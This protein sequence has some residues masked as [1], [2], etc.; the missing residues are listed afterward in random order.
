MAVVR[1]RSAPPYALI[2]FVGLWLVSTAIAVL[3]YVQ[4][5]KAEKELN[6]TTAR[7][8]RVGNRA[9]LTTYAPTLAPDKTST[10]LGTAK[11]RLDTLTALVAGSPTTPFNDAVARA[12]SAV[13]AA[14]HADN[15]SL[16]AVVQA[17]AGDRDTK[18]KQ[19]A[20]LTGQMNNVNTQ[21]RQGSEQFG[22]RVAA[23]QSDLDDT[24]RKLEAAL[25]DAQKNAASRDEAVSKAQQQ[26]S[27]A[28]A[29]MEEER[30]GSTLEMQQLRNQIARDEQRIQELLVVIRNRTSGGDQNTVGEAD[31]QIVSVNPADNEC[32]IN[33]ARNIAGNRVQAGLTFTVFDPRSGVRFATEA[34]A[35]GKGTIEIIQVGETSSLCR[36]THTTKGQAIQAG[37]LVANLVF[38]ANR[39]RTFRFVVSGDFDLD[40]DGVA[41]A[42]ERE[43]LT[44]LITSWGGAIDNDVSTQ[45][46][47]VVMGQRPAAP[48][49]PV[50][51]ATAPGGAGNQ[52][53]QQQKQYDE[54]VVEAKRLSIPVL[55]ANRFLSMIG[56]Y[57]TTV[58]RY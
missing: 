57:S 29:K 16:T 48:T 53:E 23:L 56:Y 54:L 49:L 8:E 24:R 18:A 39:N 34:D 58:V 31:G 15:E 4:W 1:A 21:I 10:A 7:V 33:L 37:D 25:Q 52:R 19:L 32:Y 50:G 28:T 12:K 30:R 5:S 9:E 35:A 43:R 42:D 55:N 26:I 14:G 3:F 41:T 13:K 27:D 51:D 44:R 40:G 20:E 46:D 11:T 36:I 47:Y 2:G 6:D 45:T 17:L 38:N 22:G